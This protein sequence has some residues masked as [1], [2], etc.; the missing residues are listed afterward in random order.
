MRSFCISGFSDALDWRPIL[1][2][3]PAIA[4]SACALCGLVSLK[5]IRFSCG[6]TLCSDCHEECSRQESI[7]PIDQESFGED[8]C[9]RIDL[10]VGFLA[11]RRA[12]CWNKFNGYNFEGPICSVLKHCMECAF[13]VVSCPRCQ[14]S[15]LRSEVVGHCKRG[16]HLPAVGPVDDTDCATQGY[17][18]I[19]QTSNEIKEA[20]GRLSEDLSC[21]QT[22]LNLCREDVRKAERSLKEQLEAHSVSLIEHLSRLHIK[23]PSLAEDRPSDVAGEVEKGCQAGNFSA[24]AE[25]SLHAKESTCQGLHPD[26]R[27]KKFHWYLRGFTALEEQALEDEAAAAESPR[28]Y[29]S[30]YN[31]SILC[32]IEWEDFFCNVYMYLEIY[33]GAYDS[34]LEWPFSKTVSVRFVHSV[35]ENLSLSFSVDTSICNGDELQRPNENSHR[36]GAFLKELKLEDIK[37]YGFVKRDTVHLY[38]E[39]V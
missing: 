19:E 36:S 25:R 32:S 9:S 22:S 30:G 33:R 1:F 12:A 8:D 6:H 5:A 18:S 23:E 14:A 37:K 28:H 31:V 17:D 2:Q 3:E 27:G 11:K 15:V 10:S 38:F 26:H 20:L 29:L 21:L 34:S 16:C 4:H 24:H 7:C 13:H 39:V 35:D